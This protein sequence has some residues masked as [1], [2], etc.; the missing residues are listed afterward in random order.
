MWSTVRN[1]PNS[2]AV[3]LSDG[4][5]AALCS[6]RDEKLVEKNHQLRAKP[7]IAESHTSEAIGFAH[8][9][10]L[11]SPSLRAE[12]G[13]EEDE[14]RQQFLFQCSLLV[15]SLPLSSHFLPAC[16]MGFPPLLP[17]FLILHTGNRHLPPSFFSSSSSSLAVMLIGAAAMGC[18]RKKASF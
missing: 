12:G 9:A 18:V 15:Q 11:P 3:Q 5:P 16:L 14:A 17:A 4:M 7:S 1:S 2:T 10:S 8:K 13:R 6:F